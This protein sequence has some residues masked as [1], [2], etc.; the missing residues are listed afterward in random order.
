[1]WLP[2]GMDGGK[3]VLSSMVRMHAFYFSMFESSLTKR[4]PPRRSET[5]TETRKAEI[6]KACDAGFW[7]LRAV[8]PTR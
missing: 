5:K 3:R 4:S 6:G 2:V 7:L 8:L 1:M